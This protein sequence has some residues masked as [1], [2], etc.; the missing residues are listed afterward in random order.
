MPANNLREDDGTVF[1]ST[2]PERTEEFC[3]SAYGNASKFSGD[4]AHFRFRA[5]LHTLGPI[6]LTTIEQTVTIETRADPLPLYLGVVR[7]HQGLRT[8]HTNDERFGPGDIGI[9]SKPGQQHMHIRNDSTRYSA[10]LIPMRTLASAAH[11]RP[12]DELGPFSLESLRPADPV[13]ARQ[14][15]RTIHYITENLRSDPEALAQPLLAGA[16]T[17]LLAASLLSAF[18]NSWTTEPRH[19]DRTDATPTTL[20]RAI[21]FIETNADRDIAL[22]DIARASYVT[23]RAVQLAFRRHLDTTP[24]AYLR[25]VRLDRAHQQLRAT[26][27]H[28]RTTIT[29]IAARWGFADHSRFTAL[30]RRTYGQLP[31][32]TLRN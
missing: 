7:I 32:Q 18:P 22:V 17:R 20:T 23:V 31:S 25:R 28:D 2:D 4:P 24:M 6:K 29:E 27:P 9:N 8:D 1:D 21:A 10:A 13:A 11:N 3:R 14:W 26:D 5:S 30:Y 19:H 16:A 15:L 12:D